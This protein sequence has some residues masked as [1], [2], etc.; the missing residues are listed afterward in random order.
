MGKHTERGELYSLANIIDRTGI[1]CELARD[2]GISERS[3][4]N[5]VERMGFT[6]QQALLIGRKLRMPGTL[7]ARIFFPYNK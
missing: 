6:T 3:L 7:W 2:L 1:A 5:K 4:Q